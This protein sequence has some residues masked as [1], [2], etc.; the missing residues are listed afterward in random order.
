MLKVMTANRLQDGDVV[1]LSE[2]GAWSEWLADSQASE[3][4]GVLQGLEARAQEAVEQRL[5]VAPYLM[6]VRSVDGR[7]EAVSQRE[8]IRARGPT[9]RED[10]GKQAQDAGARHV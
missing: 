1:Y 7:L 2:S 5:V 6:P 8:R 10:L 3:D 4:A 9:V